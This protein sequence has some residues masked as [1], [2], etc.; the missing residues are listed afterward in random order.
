[1]NLGEIIHT[2]LWYCRLC[3]A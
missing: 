2:A 3:A 1:M